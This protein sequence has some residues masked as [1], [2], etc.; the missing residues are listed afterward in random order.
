MDSAIEGEGWDL[1]R[2][3]EYLCL[4]ARLQIGPR[5]RSKLD[6]SDVVQQ[7]LLE[8]FAKR[9]QFRGTEAERAAWLR[10]VLAHNLAD[11]LRAFG[12]ARRDVGRE[13]PLSATL[14]ES[15]DRLESWLAAEQ[16]SPSHQ[17][18]RHEEAVRLAEALAAL[19]EDNREALI[20]HYFQGEPL[21]EVACLMGRTSASVAGLLKRG[22]KQLRARLNTAG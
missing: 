13:R 10:Q 9:Q 20:L 8:A 6:P 7:T 16:S 21:A 5:L 22:L 3:R 1:Q 2:Y 17:A 14:Q 18:Q 12:Q 11:A 15:S 4:L 19:P